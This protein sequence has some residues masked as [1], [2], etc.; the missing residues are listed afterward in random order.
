MVKYSYSPEHDQHDSKVFRE[1]LGTFGTTTV[2]GS[3]QLQALQAKVRQ[4]VKHVELHLAQAGKGQFNALDTPD[5]YGFEQRRTIMQLAK[6]NQ[7]TLSVHS[8]FSLSSFAG[9]SQNGFNE[10]QRWQVMK[11]VDETI[12]FAAETAKQGAIVVH[13]HEQNLPSSPGEIS[14]P[15]KYIDW[16]KKNKPQEYENLKKQ[17]FDSASPLDKQFVDNPEMINYDIKKTY[18][19]LPQDTK[20]EFQ[21]NYYKEIEEGK[22]KG[23]NIWEIYYEKQKTDK[24]KLSPDMTPLIV[25]GDK[26]DK[27]ERQQELIDV[28]LLKN[29][30]TKLT[31]DEKEILKQMGINV[32]SF[33]IDDFQRANSIFTNGLPTEYKN[34][35]INEEKFEKLKDKLLLTYDKFLSNNYNM[36][37][38]ADKKFFDKINKT[39]EEV[40]NLQKQKLETKYK[41]FQDE[42]ERINKLELQNREAFAKLESFDENDPK[43][44]ASRDAIKMHISQKNQ[45]IQHLKYNA[46]GQEDY[47]Q[48]AQYDESM[49]QINKQLTQIKEKTH[50]VKSLTEEVFKKNTASI[51][52]FGA[53]ALSYQLD[54]KNKSK[55]ADQIYSKLNKEISD[56]ENK[57]REAS[58]T[59]NFNEM[60]RI[61][62]QLSKKR[63]ELRKTTGL[64]D[65]QDIDVEKNPL[66]ISPE[67]M[68]VGYGYMTNLEEYKALIRESWKEFS[69]KITSDDDFYKSIRENYEKQTGKKVTK[70][71]AYEIA[72]K[73][74]GG[75]FDNAHAGVWLKYFKKKP[76]ES[77]EARIERFNKW[78]NNQAE[79]M[80][81]EGIIKHVHMNDSLGKDDDH[82][83]LGTGILDFHDLKHRL[84]K[85]GIKEPMIVEAGGRGS[86]SNLHLTN[87]FETF[88][89]SL[90]SKIGPSASFNSGV[91]DWISVKK[92][93][94]N[95]PQYSS[96]GMSYSTFKHV[97]PQQ[98]QEKG[99][100]SGT[101]FF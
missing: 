59:D 88:N 99:E 20:E 78:L 3:D 14:L 18:E 61:N 51:A 84:R 77:E 8:E 34:K 21:K 9:I 98:G 89:T 66:Y 32:D 80:A 19:D 82:N 86:A 83:L 96:Y 68:I 33:A 2:P 27:V 40:L 17:Y 1:S 45:E 74:I 64:K 16:L 43:S 41:M 91:S 90:N 25:V 6:L 22:K 7:Q 81:K 42:L 85:A 48:L 38:L 60:E 75:T 55:D 26:I 100:W 67:N 5:K 72:K 31:N 56:L 57:Y 73:H 36:A 50:N 54:L 12:K 29:H 95:R 79:D 37:S 94:Q 30:P 46:I 87:A 65:Y 53:K 69:E 10:S 52:H 24:M 63:N 58:K 47:H 39:Q 35:G 23:K 15:K 76:N 13:I 44:K 92:D 97:P 4:G 93:Y 62:T 71:N 49:A 70:E 28:E 11:E 101:S